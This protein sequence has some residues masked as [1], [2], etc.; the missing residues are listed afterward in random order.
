MDPSW[1][2]VLWQRALQHPNVAVQRL[3]LRTFL[4]RDWGYDPCSLAEG[5]GVD[6]ATSSTV[7][8]PI[9][10]PPVGFVEG[11]LLPTLMQ[12]EAH[13]KPAAAAD[14][15]GFNTE[16]WIGLCEHLQTDSTLIF[17]TNLESLSTSAMPLSLRS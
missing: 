8:L 9:P 4:Q 5:C 15:S 6:G 14:G 2:L 12:R 17:V 10:F 1:H 16:V 3:G 13:F 11:V 7:A